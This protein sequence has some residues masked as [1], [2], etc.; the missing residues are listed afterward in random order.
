MICCAPCNLATPPGSLNS[1][2]S[3]PLIGHWNCSLRRGTQ[4]ANHRRGGGAWRGGA[5][6]QSACRSKK[7]RGSCRTECKRGEAREGRQLTGEGESEPRLE[8]G[9]AR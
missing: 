8:Q 3:S 6:R 2:A 4:A 9:S 1:S 7:N 5:E